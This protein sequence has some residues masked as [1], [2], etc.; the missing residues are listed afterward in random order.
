MSCN[1]QIERCPGCRKSLELGGLPAFCPGC[2]LRFGLENA[3]FAGP[4][5]LGPDDSNCGG[6]RLLREG[7]PRFLGD[8]E[9]LNEIGRGGM[10]VVYRAHHRRLNRFVALKLILV[11]NLADLATMQRFNIEARI[12]ASLEH[13]N[14]VPV[15]EIAEDETLPFFVMKLAEG[16]NLADHVDKSWPL[17]QTPIERNVGFRKHQEKIA[18][19]MVKI[20]RAVAYS[21]GCGV[22]HLDLKPSNILLDGDGEP[23]VS[24]F[25]LAKILDGENMRFTAE[26]S[27]LGSPCWMAPEQACADLKREITTATDIHGLGALLYLLL[28]GR[29]PFRGESVFEILQKVST[30]EPEP[31]SGFYPALDR[32][33]ETICLCCLRKRPVDRYDSAAGLADDLERFLK[34]IP[35]AAREVSA[36]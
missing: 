30:A 31:L 23:H 34:R 24:D 1:S 20:A 8:C 27:I 2:L 32:D 6:M 15:Y 3:L 28:T 19:F 18:A 11:G 4:D 22:L 35:I 9:L 26:A 10:G 33:L 13:P 5:F 17:P 29:P 21:H 25:G 16:G 36:S 7:L 12:G 14:I